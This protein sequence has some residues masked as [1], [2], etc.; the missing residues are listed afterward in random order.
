MPQ[1]CDMVIE[2]DMKKV[3]E[4]MESNTIEEEIRQIHR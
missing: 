1:S 3:L 2:I 4:G